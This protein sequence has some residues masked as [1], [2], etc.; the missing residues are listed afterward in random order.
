MLD[1]EI[2]VRFGV[3]G[4]EFDDTAV[5]RDRVLHTFL[6][7]VKLSEREISFPV[8]R[9]KSDGAL[10]VGF[11]VRDLAHVLVHTSQAHQGAAIARI[12][13]ESLLKFLKGDVV[14]AKS[15]VEMAESNVD[16]RKAIIDL[17]RLAAICEGL[18]D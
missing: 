5:L 16:S 2:A 8:V 7:A 3:V 1:A 9:P 12:D 11:G 18:L 4:R 15:R 17:E 13:I 14:L 10:V 6:A